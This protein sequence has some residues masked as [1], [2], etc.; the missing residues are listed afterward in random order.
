MDAHKRHFQ[1]FMNDT[2]VRGFGL[3]RQYS[4]TDRRIDF[5]PYQRADLAGVRR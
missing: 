1:D 2:P 5:D 4:N 3:P